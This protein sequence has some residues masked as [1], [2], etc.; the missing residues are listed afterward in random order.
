MLTLKVV[1][2][3]MS[4]TWN[5]PTNAWMAKLDRA[6]VHITAL[7]RDVSA[8][9]GR[10]YEVVREPGENPGDVRLRLR[11]HEPIP[12][13]FST[14]IGD[15]VHNMRSALDTFAYHL[16]VK[17]VVRALTDDEQARTSFPIYARRNKLDRFFADRSNLF[18]DRERRTMM[19]VTPGWQW[20]EFL[21]KADA[22]F[23]VTRE[24]DAQLSPIWT[25]HRLWNIDKHR[26]VH[27]AVWWPKIT[28]WSGSDA[29]SHGWIGGDAPPLPGLRR[30]PR[31][32][33]CP[34]S[35]FG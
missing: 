35:N 11:L 13:G 33:S 15:A 14:T 2:Q 32:T 23:R 27:L 31:A 16:A 30:Q 28:Y 25:L 29:Q 26:R 20:D 24:E 10:A 8:F 12:I 9:E 4:Y 34:A 7:H 22:E 18:G 3:P 1:S 6:S 17:H 5:D 19:A 21:H